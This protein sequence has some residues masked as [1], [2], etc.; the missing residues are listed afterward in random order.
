[1]T[2]EKVLVRDEA[3]SP[4]TKCVNVISLVK[5]EKDKS[6]E[7]NEVVDNSIVEPSKLNVVEPIKLVDWKNEM[8]DVAD[9]K[10]V[11]SVKEELTGWETKACVIVEMPMSQPIGYYLKHE[12]NEKII[13]GLVDN[14]KYKNSL[15]ATCL[16]KMDYETYNSLPAGPMYNVILK[17]MLAKKDD[18]E[19]NFVIP[20]SIGRLKYVNAL[21][22]QGSDVN[23]MTISIYN[24][25]TNEKL[26]G[27]DIRLSLASHSYIYPLGIDE[28]VLIDIVGYVYLVD[29]VILDIEE[30]KSKPFI[31]GTPFLTT[32]K[33]EIRFDKGTITLKSGKNKIN[34]FKIFTSSYYITLLVLHGL[35]VCVFGMMK[36]GFLD[37]R[38]GVK[39]KRINDSDSSEKLKTSNGMPI[40]G[41]TLDS[42][43]PCNNSPGVSN[44]YANV[45]VESIR[46]ISERFAN[47]T[48]GFFL[49]KRVAY[50][51]FSSMDG[52][53]AMLEHVW[54][55]LHG[56]LV[57]AFS[58]DSLSAIAT[59]LGTPLMLDSYTSDTC[60]QSWGMSSYARAMIEDECPMN[61]DSNVVKNMKK[62]SQTHRGVPIGHK[63]GFQP[64]KQVYRQVSKKNNV[65]TSGNKKKDVEPIIEVSKSNP[66]DVLNSVENDVDLGTNGGTSYMASKEVNSSGS[67]FCNVDSSS[68]S[69]TPIV[70][71]IDKM[72][73][74]IIDGMTTLVDDEDKPLTR[75]DSSSDHDSE[76]EVASVDNDMAKFLASKDVG[77]G[78]NSLLEQWKESYR[79]GEYD[80]DPY[81][82]DM[83][84]G[85][86]IPNKI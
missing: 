38:G 60:L 37:S 45:T 28:N 25:L 77:Y 79:N 61:K 16:G 6:I 55:K 70:D 73:R 33:I 7:N 81:D 80:Y 62:P 10:L 32:A 69:T 78:T 24:R 54:V 34:F 51:I 42:H 83:Y 20:C 14:H 2:P 72:E 76:D 82:D 67:S 75:V 52:L 8:E 64:A 47:T 4:I 13:E 58:E 65:S 29:F 36:A 49:R 40:V 12:I 56:V 9:D 48:Y 84:E 15:L 59:K 41:L 39:K 63:V 53:N 18:I 27:T 5:M 31:L 30:D 86:D 43:K 68:I 11:K 66:F 50:P 22:D 44:S 1:M 35:F 21:I 23:V 3:S 57:T 19:G 26:V 71:K 85:Q 74:L 46:A 17:K